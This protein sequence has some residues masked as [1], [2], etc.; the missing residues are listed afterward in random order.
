MNMGSRPTSKIACQFAEEWLEAWRLQLD[1]F[2]L[3]WL[4]T[5]SAEFCRI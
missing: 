5:K 4:E 2:V 1:V 3:S